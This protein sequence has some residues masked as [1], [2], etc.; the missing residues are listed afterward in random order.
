MRAGAGVFVTMTIAIPPYDINPTLV[1]LICLP[2]CAF[3]IE[4]FFLISTLLE[5]LCNNTY[6]AVVIMQLSPT[7]A[8]FLNNSDNTFE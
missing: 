3:L 5:L 8:V 4:T 7:T 1:S 2:T 6:T